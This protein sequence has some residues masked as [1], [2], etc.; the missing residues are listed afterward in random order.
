MI[1]EIEG[2]IT[3]ECRMAPPTSDAEMNDEDGGRPDDGD[4]GDD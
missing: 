1:E 3:E 4:D 2:G